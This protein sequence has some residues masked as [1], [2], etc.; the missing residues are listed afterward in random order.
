ML[1]NSAAA[2]DPPTL[3]DV[4][5]A[6]WRIRGAVIRP[7]IVASALGRHVRLVL[8]CLQPTGAFKLRGATNAIAT[9]PTNAKARGVVCCSTGNHARAL[10]HAGRVAGVPVTVCLSVLVPDNKIAAIEAL[11]AEVIR[12]GQSQD[13]AQ[14]V[15]TQLVAERGLT[16]LP[17]FDHPAIVAGQGTLGL[18]LM[19][20]WPEVETILVPLSGGGLAGGVA[21]AAKAIKPSVRVVG[22]SMDRGAAMAESLSAGRPIRVEEVPS[23]ADS[24]GGGIGLDNRITFHLCRDLL[25]DVILVTEVEIYRGLHAL[26]TQERLFAEGG[27]A[28]GHAAILAEKFRVKGPTAVLVTGRNAPPSQLAAIAECHPVC[29]GDIT[30]EPPDDA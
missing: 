22:V 4:A 10:A 8:D 11:G 5:A 15:A 12:T 13:E 9:L 20:A 24:L 16:D 21:L 3:E 28:V 1:Q 17:P 6:R 14:E 2:F 18:D 25:D 29:L 27:A 26:L 30:V 7:P 23:L 19:D